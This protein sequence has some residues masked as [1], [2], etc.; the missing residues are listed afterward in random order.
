VAGDRAPKATVDLRVVALRG[1]YSIAARCE[2][3]EVGAIL[4]AGQAAPF[5]RRFMPFVVAGT[6]AGP[7]SYLLTGD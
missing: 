3:A 1:I 4:D 6:A 7:I 5:R 2:L